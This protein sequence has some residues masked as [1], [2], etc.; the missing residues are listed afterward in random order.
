MKTNEIIVEMYQKSNCEFEKENL[1]NEL[2]EKNEKMCYSI[3]NKFRNSG[4]DLEDLMQACRVCIF[5]LASKFDISLGVKF[6]T[7]AYKSMYLSCINY[8]RDH[9][10]KFDTLSL[11]FTYDNQ[12]EDQDK[13]LASYI[14]FEENFDSKLEFEHIKEKVSLYVEDNFKGKTN[15]VIKYLLDNPYLKNEEIAA[16]MGITPNHVNSIKGRVKKEMR[17][18]LGYLLEI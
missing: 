15:V 2:L 1:L 14:A 7:F 3:I 17:S 18:K 8:I 10:N 13:T 12:S 16:K 9:K 4:M 5:R 6:G 11:D